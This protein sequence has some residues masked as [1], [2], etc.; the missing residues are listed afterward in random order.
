MQY[1]LLSAG[2]NPPSV[3]IVSDT[4]AQ[5]LA[6]HCQNF[7]HWLHHSPQAAAYR[8]GNVVYDT[9]KDFI[10]KTPVF[11]GYIHDNLILKM[12]PGT[13]LV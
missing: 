13:I 5:N 10:K 1:I 7:D 9:E 8:Q 11:I 12:V 2:N 3:Y 6:I 4:I